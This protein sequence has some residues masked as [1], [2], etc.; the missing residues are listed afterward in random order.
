MSD[1]SEG[2]LGT[3]MSLMSF[4]LL[5]AIVWVIY[6]FW[7]E[8]I[9]VLNFLVA[10][11]GGCIL[12]LVATLVSCLSWWIAA[13]IIGRVKPWN[14]PNSSYNEETLMM[15]GVIAAVAGIVSG[16]WSFYAVDKGWIDFIFSSLLPFLLS[17]AGILGLIRPLYERLTE[18]PTNVGTRQSGV[19]Y[20]SSS[21]NSF[22]SD[23]GVGR[24]VN[25]E[26]V[27]LTDDGQLRY[28]T[29]SDSSQRSTRGAQ[30]VDP[31]SVELTED[32]EIHFRAR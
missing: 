30:H 20:S 6:T 3:V 14:P 15:I 10:F 1:D 27:E 18:A 21:S 22:E 24:H 13:A 23:G 9:A 25:Y 19:N 7:D 5:V 28:R 12:G 16:I 8:I 17:G 26:S 31:S 2:C 4:I 32:G 29:E 11:V